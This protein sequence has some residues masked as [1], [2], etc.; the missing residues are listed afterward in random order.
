MRNRPRTAETLKYG[1]RKARRQVDQAHNTSAP[2]N[3]TDKAR[4]ARD[5]F[6]KTNPDIYGGWHPQTNPDYFLQG[7]PPDYRENRISDLNWGL[8][9][10]R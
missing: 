5:A 6:A 7:T 8:R 10:K 1:G 4:D 9:P 3:T 2:T